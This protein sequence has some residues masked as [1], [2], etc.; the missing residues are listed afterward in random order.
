MSER[1]VKLYKTEM[2]RNWQEI[3]T[4]RYGHKCRF[5]HGQEELRYIQR[6]PKYK[7]QICRTFHLTGTCLYGVRCVFIHDE[8]STKF[9]SFESNGFFTDF[10]WLSGLYRRCSSSSSSSS[11]TLV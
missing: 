10:T 8:P 5:A 7:T 11:S 2:C 4:C 3:G 6:S 9:D 1:Q